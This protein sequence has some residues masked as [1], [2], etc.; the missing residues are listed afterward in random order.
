MGCGHENRDSVQESAESSLARQA[1]AAGKGEDRSAG[2]VNRLVGLQAQQAQPPFIGLWTRVTGFEREALL[3]LLRSREIVRSTLMRGT[4]HLMSAD[5]YLS[6]RGT[7]QPGLSA[8][9]H[10]VLRDRAKGLDI[11]ALVAE[12]LRF[13]R[14]R[15]RTFTELRAALM[16]TFPDADECAIGYAVR[17]HL[18]LVAVP[19]DSEWGFR[20]DSNFADAESWL[21]TSPGSL[22]RPDTLVLRYLAAFGPAAAGDVQAWS[23]LTGIRNVLDELR[24]RLRVFRD[25]RKRELFDLAEA[26]RPSE[27]TPSPVRFLP[28][29]DNVIL[30]HADRTRIMAD[31]HRP[32]VTTKN[33]LV[34]PTFL[35][36]GFV[37]GTWKHAR[38]KAAAC[39]T[40]SP[41]ARLPAAAKAQLAEEGEK[42]VRFVVP[43][44]NQWTT[45]F[46]AP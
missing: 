12:A 20:A 4:L 2:A 37:A 38:V 6:L 15:P 29:F 14:E 13:F 34:L 22:E 27:D 25:E 44:A 9:M 21:G 16:D 3:R 32:R 28:G 24:P 10:S 23:G 1:D 26:P 30:S 41:F 11:P 40:V 33:L 39:L 43:E 7:L 5:D 17:T 42:L 36:D 46:A 45:Q 18:P 8:G 31:E 19:D 35:V